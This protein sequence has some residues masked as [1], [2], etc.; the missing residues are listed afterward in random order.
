MS[1][2]PEPAPSSGTPDDRRLILVEL[3]EIN[4]EI[5]RGYIDRLGLRH[6]RRLLDGC[7]RRTAA[8]SRYEQ[9]E[10]WIQ[11][12]SAHSGL[13]ADEHGIFRLGDI[14]GSGVPQ[15]F[16]ELEAAGWRVGCLSAMNAENRLRRPAYFIPDPWTRTPS[17]GSF[18]SEALGAAVGQAVN[19][20]ADGRLTARSAAVLA[21]GLLR[22]AAPR[23]W[24]LYASLAAR[25]RGAPWRKAL[26]LD[27]F[28]HDLHLALFRRA[29]PH[30]STLFL[31][32]GAH[33]QHHYFLNVPGAV[34][35]GTQRNPD[36]YVHPA[37]DP[38]GEMLQV[39]DRI[40]GELLDEPGTE[41][42]VAT[43]LSQRPYDRVKYYWRLRDHAD[44]LRRIGVAFV[45]V[46]PRMTRDFLVICRDAAEAAAAQAALAAA[47]LE[48]LDTPVFGE[49]DNRGDSLFVTLTYPDE[50]RP[51]Q[52]LAV[53]GRRVELHPLVTFVA[54]K[55]GMH[56]SEGY[57]FFSPRAARHAP[58]EGAHVSALYHAVRGFF[59]QATAGA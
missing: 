27:L 18:W 25:S 14:V 51:G 53:G 16:E 19:D 35:P 47:R 22:F 57:A 28:L 59:G 11:W 36:W 34:P 50:I 38:V 23:H 20:N 54:I 41:L 58:E 43:G 26:M 21:L 17:D 33:I 5:A 39:Y 44:F 32:A 55:N 48:G 30:F 6:L 40:V 45:E 31:N 12:V 56:R 46:Q 7:M 42:I 24:G 13:K 9:L 49:I 10:P 37:A 2:L 8:E 1:S 29:R 3:N 15:M 52:M 4:F